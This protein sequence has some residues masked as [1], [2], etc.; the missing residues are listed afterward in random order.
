MRQIGFK[1]LHFGCKFG[2]LDNFIILSFST[3]DIARHTINTG[4]EGELVTYDLTLICK[5]FFVCIRSIFW[6]LDAF[7]CRE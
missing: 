4:V 7:Q 5:V 6:N 2:P 1:L 3:V